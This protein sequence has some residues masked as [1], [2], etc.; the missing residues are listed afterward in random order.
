MADIKEMLDRDGFVGP[1]PSFLSGDE[2]D[3]L[4]AELFQIVEDKPIHPLYDRFS[5]RDWHL[6]STRVDHLMTHEKLVENIVPL[7]GEHLNLW[8][9]KIF[10]KRPGD[11]EVGWHQ[12]WGRFNGEEIGND[13]PSLAP[14]HGEFSPWNVSIWFALDDMTW[15]NGPLQFVRGSHRTRYPIDFVPMTASGFFHLPLIGMTRAAQVVR[16]AERRELVLDI[17]TRDMFANVDWSGWDL[18]QTR[19]FVYRWLDG[20]KAAVTLPFDTPADRLVTML[21]RKG[22]Y[23]V[24]FERT[25]H[26]SLPN[27]T[28]GHRVA[29]N[30]RV[31]PTD[32][33]VYPS[34]LQGDFIDGSNLDITDHRCVLLC[35]GV[36]DPRNVYREADWADRLQPLDALETVTT[37]ATRLAREDEAALAL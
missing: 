2:V 30:A 20:K 9:T 15:E 17:D 36:L 21:M 10:H 14:A 13:K 12:E 18:E 29:I 23:V 34:R 16:A 1:L 25:M 22:E 8:R 35:G 6:L 5:V 31:T 32:T 24:F 19:E 33:L 27:R 4:R 7:L 28:A 37:R 11:A 26:R 3:A